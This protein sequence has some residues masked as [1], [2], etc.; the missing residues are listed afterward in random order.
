[1]G[2]V[3]SCPLPSVFVSSF[4][5]AA[6]APNL[7][8]CDGAVYAI[9][10]DPN[11]FGV[12][13]NN[14]VL[15][16]QATVPA[17]TLQ[18][19]LNLQVFD[20][21]VGANEIRYVWNSANVGCASPTEENG[22]CLGL[23]F[24]E[25]GLCLLEPNDLCTNAI[26][27]SCGDAVSGSTVNATP[28]GAPVC[29]VSQNT[30]GVWY[31]LTNAAAGDLVT[32]DLCGSN[33]D[34]KISVYEDGCGVLTCV[35]G[36]DDSGC[37]FTSLFSFT[38][39]GGDYLILVHGFDVGDEGDFDLSITCQT[40]GCTDAGAC[41]YD[42][43]AQ[44]DD[45][46]CDYSCI[47]CNNFLA[48][49]YGGPAITINDG[50]C[51]F[52]NCVTLTLFD[53]LDDSWNGA[54]YTVYDSGNA[55]VS[56]GTL[57]ADESGLEIDLCLNDGCYSI[58]VTAGSWP[59]E[60]S[61]SLDGIDNVGSYTGGA[62]ETYFF[63]VNGFCPI[64]GCTDVNALN[65]NPAAN[66][67]DG[68]C[69]VAD[70]APDPATQFTYCYAVNES[71]L[72]V[73]A[74]NNPGVDNVL[75]N[76]LQGNAEVGFDLITIY[77]GPSVAS[78]VL[79]SGTNIAGQVFESTGDYISIGISSDS[80]VSC[81]SS[82][83]IIDI[84]VDVYCGAETA[85]TFGC[86][87]AGALNYDPAAIVDDGTCIIPDCAPDPAT[88]FTYCY[89]INES[90]VFTFV[91][92][93]P[94]VDNV[95]LDLIQGNAEVGF[96]VI[97]IYDGPDVFSPVLFSG[98]NVAG[99]VFESSGDAISIGIS[100]DSSVSCVSSLS[101]VDLIVDVYCG[102]LDS[103][104]CTDTNA[105][106]YDPS[107]TS[108]DGSC[109]YPNA[110]DECAGAVGV[111]IGVASLVD[112]TCATAGP[113][114]LPC[115]FGGDATQNDVWVSFVAPASGNVVIETSAD[116][117]FTLTDTQIGLYDA[118]GGTQL[119]CDDDSGVSLFS[120]I[121][122]PAC[123]LTAGATYYVQ[124]DGYNGD[125]GTCNI[126]VSVTDLPGCTDPA[127][128]N[129][130]VCATIDDG[131][132]IYA[133]P[134]LAI[135]PTFFPGCAGVAG[136]TSIPGAG[137]GL[138]SN[139]PFGGNVDDEVFYELVAPCNGALKVVVDG[140]PGFDAVVELMD[141]SFTAL[142]AVDATLDGG[143]EIAY[144]AGIVAGDTYYVRVYD[145][146][147][148]VTG[149]FN[150]CLT[151]YCASSP[152]APYPTLTY[153]ACDV[154][155]C[156]F[157]PGAAGYD[158]SL[159]PQGGGATLTY[160]S[161]TNYT[162]LDLQDLS[163]PVQYGVTYDV[164]IDVRFTDPDLGN[165]VVPGMITDVLVMD[166]AP[167]TE[168]RSDFVGGTYQLN[169]NI[170]CVQS[171]GADQYIWRLTPVGGSALP[172]VT[173]PGTS[174]IVNLCS[175]AGILP[176]TTYDVEVAVVY[177]GVQ[178]AFGP[179]NQINTA[180]QP[181]V[182]LRAA[183]KCSVAGPLALGHYIFTNAFVPCAKDWTWEFTR[184]D[185][186][187]LPIYWKKG[188]GV[189]SL[190]LS[191]VK[192]LNTNIPL[193]AAGGTYN[194]RV[195]PEYGNFLGQGNDFPGLQPQYDYAT[196]YGATEQICIVGGAIADGGQNSMAPQDNEPV[197]AAVA[198]EAA[199]YPNPTN[200]AFVNLNINNIDESNDRILV[201][202]YDAF[203][204]L[205]MSEQIAV[206]GSSMNTVLNFNKEMANGV[207]MVNIIVGGNVQ[208]ERLVIQK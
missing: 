181:I 190:R 49:N 64:L 81:Q 23:I 99:F 55:V 50:S 208:T 7:N 10:G 165:I 40:Q 100:S 130:N 33:F 168:L 119:G 187:E 113:D 138:P 4:G 193:L 141:A 199:L 188:D 206:T 162:F 117:S 53:S 21:G 26:D 2:I 158:W 135:N 172:D 87:D 20:N 154:Y 82:G 192:D 12:G 133:L 204:K 173:V 3:A 22:E 163:G 198:I 207:Y 46:S 86:T 127:A 29:G 18:Y 24:P 166:A 45:G 156:D 13:P 145:W 42:A 68:S 59:A 155:K 123:D 69:I 152:D 51:C 52:A 11:G 183:D 126:T 124:I 109:Q 80:S 96:D 32:L 62:P 195:K 6:S 1:V 72:F 60:V 89:T 95:V 189:R 90:P 35:G 102:V 56:T 98:T 31:N 14:R 120:L 77:D 43:G 84:I 38:A 203:G 136:A 93:N 184:V 28:D 79:F 74:S 107:A 63:S 157:I 37:G 178:Y 149:T 78:P 15:L 196:S 115:S 171:C 121:T 197:R 177:G 103:P 128:A 116:G 200:G 170:R 202:I 191:N 5:T 114:A 139:G 106:N 34:T 110:D 85:V 179:V 132:C 61:W 186:P 104:G 160:S 194:V 76:C 83:A 175:F 176:S 48:C 17:G 66:T 161:P 159:V 39:D 97:T 65:Y 134:T 143:V 73:F 111:A 137:S 41:N 169:A 9:I 8:V 36:D 75:L 112:N 94:G 150:I 19:N 70:C 144:S 25:P 108:D 57:N 30:N 67:D 92:T 140:D 147:T 105:C 101:I 153:Q 91:S 146:F 71:P 182:F 129:Y 180:A 201:D 125:A 151:A 122:I 174:T 44:V 131:S 54:V 164:T 142:D 47:G 16:F 88:Q 58:E 185:V 167:Q 118:C 148:G 27:V 205:V